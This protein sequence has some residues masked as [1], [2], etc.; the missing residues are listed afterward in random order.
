MLVRAGNDEMGEM[1]IGRGV[2]RGYYFSP[3]LIW[4]KLTEESLEKARGVELKRERI[5]TLNIQ[6]VK[7]SAESEKAIQCM[8]QRIVRVGKEFELKVNI[9]KTKVKRIS[10]N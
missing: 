5:K 7:Q 4:E 3:T 9:G 6:I 10:R 2:R 1:C 8:V